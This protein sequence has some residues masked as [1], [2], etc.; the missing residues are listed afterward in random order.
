[1]KAVLRRNFVALSASIKK[2][3]SYKTSNLKAVENK[4]QKHQGRAEGR[5]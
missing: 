5:T 2:L 1:M 4:N 3:E